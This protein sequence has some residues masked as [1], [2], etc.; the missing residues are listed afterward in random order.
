MGRFADSHKQAPQQKTINKGARRRKRIYLTMM[1]LFL[2]WAG[3]TLFSLNDRIY[4]QNEKLAERQKEY[5]AV[6]Q[7]LAELQHE[8]ERL[9]D[10]EYIGQIARRKFGLY[11]PNETPIIQPQDSV[12][13][14]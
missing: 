2:V 11:L 12:K 4:N 8:V 7:S 3:S 6:N 1:A 10:P 13:E 14:P 9:E 5:T